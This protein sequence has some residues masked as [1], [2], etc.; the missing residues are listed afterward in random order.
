M[1]GLEPTISWLRVQYLNHS[2][3]RPSP[4]PKFVLLR[5]AMAGAR[6]TWYHFPTDHPISRCTILHSDL[7]ISYKKYHSAPSRLSF[8]LFIIFAVAQLKL[9]VL[10]AARFDDYI[11]SAGDRLIPHNSVLWKVRI[12]SNHETG[13]NFF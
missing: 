10:Y 13:I 11:F 7:H 8:F 4:L 1:A 3:V 9:Y 5:R 12:K 6:A 2:P